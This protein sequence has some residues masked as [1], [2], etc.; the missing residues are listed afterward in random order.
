TAD[1]PTNATGLFFSPESIDDEGCHGEMEQYEVKLYNFTGAQTTVSLTYYQDFWGTFW[2]P[3]GFTLPD[4]AYA[5]FFVDVDPHV[6]TA[7]RDIFGMIEATDGTDMATFE[8][9]KQMYSEK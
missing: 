7:D 2:G 9:H 4:G 8:L 5:S 6:C 1:V 3:T